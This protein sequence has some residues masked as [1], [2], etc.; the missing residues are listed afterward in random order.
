MMMLLSNVPSGPLVAVP[1]VTVCAALSLFV[2]VTVPPTA[3]VTVCGEK[4]SFFASQPG[5]EDPL[6]IETSADMAAIGFGAGAGVGAG[7]GAGVGAGAGAGVGAGAGAGVGAGAG[8]G[9]GAGAGAGVGAVII[10]VFVVVPIVEL[11]RANAI[12]ATVNPIEKAIPNL[13]ALVIIALR[14]GD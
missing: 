8:A 5:V 9:V 14:F 6:G 3:T 1:L 2:H 13:S 10:G 12:S 11:E 7:A 4:H